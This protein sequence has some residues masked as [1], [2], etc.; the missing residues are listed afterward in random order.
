MSGLSAKER[1]RFGRQIRL[2]EVGEVGQERLC[3]AS[4]PLTSTTELARWVE[5]RYL[6]ASGVKV[7]RTSARV[8]PPPEALNALGLRHAAAREVASGALLALDAIRAALEGPAT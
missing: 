8:A 7:D 3:R 5:E 1:R 6:L 2:P 4:V